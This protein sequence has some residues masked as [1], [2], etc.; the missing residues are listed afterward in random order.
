MAVDGLLRPRNIEGFPLRRPAIEVCTLRLSLA[1]LADPPA[2]ASLITQ[3]FGASPV[4][5]FA[6]GSFS[7]NFH[8]ILT[9]CCWHRGVIYVLTGDLNFEIAVA[10]RELCVL[11]VVLVLL[12]LS[13]GLRS[14]SARTVTARGRLRC[15]R[16]SCRWRR[17]GG[18]LCFSGVDRFRP[19]NLPFVSSDQGR[20]LW[21]LCSDCCLDAIPASFAVRS[22]CH[23]K[24]LGL[25]AQ[26]IRGV[27]V[28][29]KM[30][31][32]DLEVA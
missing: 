16:H 9:V 11:V 26:A 12:L 1:A 22:L 17:C 19:F 21:V 23:I 31:G 27:A 18:S 13:T 28:L 20:R 14:P 24:Q 25:A 10:G 29:L 8:V 7:I 6:L 30:R 32:S 15:C 3:D 4:I 2:L 5:V